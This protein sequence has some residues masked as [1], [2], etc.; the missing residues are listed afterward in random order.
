[1]HSRDFPSLPLPTQVSPKQVGTGSSSLAS[2]EKPTQ[3][4]PDSFGSF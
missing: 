4:A 1:M 3:P 2:L